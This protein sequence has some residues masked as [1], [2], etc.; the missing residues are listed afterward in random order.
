RAAERHAL[1]NGAAVTYFR[2]FADHHAHAVVDE[3]ARAEPGAG[4]DLDPGERAAEVRGKAPEQLEPVQPEPARELVDVDRVQAGIAGQYL[5]R[6][7]R[8]RVALEDAGD[9][10]AQSREHPAILWVPD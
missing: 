7:A 4:M 9:I 6:R 8:R 5:P 1:V 10:A 3:D 2:S